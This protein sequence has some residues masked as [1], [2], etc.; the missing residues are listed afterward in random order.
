[1]KALH[2]YL[3]FSGACAEAMH[4]YHDC[5]GGELTLQK[6]SESP[7]ASQMPP[8]MQDQILHSMLMIGDL[9]LMASDMQPSWRTA[10]ST[11]SCMLHCSSEEE[12]RKTFDAL[13]AGGTIR[14][15]VKAQFWGGV[16][17]AVTDKFGIDWSLHYDLSQQ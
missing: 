3:T 7:I 8:A 11:V 12:L 9:S 5:L 13:A 1:M 16:F 6:I 15:P 17:G 14:D 4:F 10:G 2:P